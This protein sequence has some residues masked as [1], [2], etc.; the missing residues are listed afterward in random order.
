MTTAEY[1][2]SLLPV[3]EDYDS[4]KGGYD[5]IKSS[6]YNEAIDKI[7]D[8]LSKVKVDEI[9]AKKIVENN[10]NEYYNVPDPVRVEVKLIAYYPENVAK[11]LT[12]TNILTVEEK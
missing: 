1:L 10:C 11:A 7:H 9:K 4:L 12:Q 2:V 8:I 3:R 6:G 5:N